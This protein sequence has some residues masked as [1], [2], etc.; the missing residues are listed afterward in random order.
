MMDRAENRNTR[1]VIVGGAPIGN[2]ADVKKYIKDDDYIIF[3]DCGLAHMDSLGVA[4]SLVVG[5][6]DSHEAPEGDFEVIKLPTQKDDTD[7]VYAAKEAIRRGF[8]NFLLIGMVGGTMDHTLANV[9]ILMYMDALGKRA[10][11]VDDYS[12]ME[13]ISTAVSYIDDGFE[14]FSVLSPNGT[15][16]GINISD[17]KYTLE[18]GAI[19]IKYQYGVRNE[20]L[21]GKIARVSV[22][23]GC[24]LVVK[25][26]K[27]K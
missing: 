4:S 6:F 27:A 10:V 20:P 11:L 23:E 8:C 22:E 25:I 18:D 13:V 15:A 16:S 12:E 2:Y 9:S 1:C 14:Y 7:T 5:D 3:C 21:P 24:L 17:A 19:N 26:R